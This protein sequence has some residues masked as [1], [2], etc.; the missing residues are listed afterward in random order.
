MKLTIRPLSA[1][2]IRARPIMR[3]PLGDRERI[4]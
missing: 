3:Y 1:R 4:D 2:H